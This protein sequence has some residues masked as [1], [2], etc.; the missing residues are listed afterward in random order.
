MLI[1]GID[2]QGG[3]CVI[4]E[5]LPSGTAFAAAGITVAPAAVTSSSPPP[6]RPPGRGDLVGVAAEPGIASWNFI[7]FP[8]GAKTEIHH[9]DSVDFDVVL[10]GSVNL[11]LDDGPHRLDAGDGVVVNGVDHGW[12]TEESGCRM[13]VVVIATPP[14]D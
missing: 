2:D 12:Q 7:E 4:E 9:T 14:L 6:P 8:A 11:L 3:S 10:D 5:R 13:S 1:T